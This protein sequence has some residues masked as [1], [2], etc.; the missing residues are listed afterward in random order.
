MLP[1]GGEECIVRKNMEKQ[2]KVKNRLNW[3]KIKR[4]K[5]EKVLDMGSGVSE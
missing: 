4:R 1:G 2:R 3:R 5:G